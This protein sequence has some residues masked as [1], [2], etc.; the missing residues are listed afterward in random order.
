[1]VKGL[2]FAPLISVLYK[3]K[4]DQI[5][6]HIMILLVISIHDQLNLYLKKAFLQILIKVQ[7]EMVPIHDTFQTD[8]YPNIHPNLD[9]FDKCFEC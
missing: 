3:N 5:Q 1:M 2:N 8:V 7:L 4:N 9:L 6:T